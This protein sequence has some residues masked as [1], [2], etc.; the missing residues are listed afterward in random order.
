MQEEK[1]EY[2]EYEE[3][4]EEVADCFVIIKEDYTMTENALSAVVNY[5]WKELGEKDDDEYVEDENKK[6]MG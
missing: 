2:E 6:C 5:A 1:E 3:Y 4:E